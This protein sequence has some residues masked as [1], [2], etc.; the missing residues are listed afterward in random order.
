MKSAM[1]KLLFEIEFDNDSSP[2]KTRQNS[3][4]YLRKF[5][6]FRKSII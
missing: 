6:A 2:Y 1:Q 5:T 3:D 4:V